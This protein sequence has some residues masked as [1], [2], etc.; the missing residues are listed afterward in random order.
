MIFMYNLSNIT[1][2]ICN[3]CWKGDSWKNKAI[4]NTY[5]YSIWKLQEWKFNVF[6][7]TKINYK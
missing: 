4:S 7:F 5:Q 2:E 1:T 6:V 3:Y